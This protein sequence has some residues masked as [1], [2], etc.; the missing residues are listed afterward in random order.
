MAKAEMEKAEAGGLAV[1]PERQ[2]VYELLHQSMLGEVDL[3]ESYDSEE[4]QRALALGLLGSESL[5]ELYGAQSLQ[6]WSELLGKPM[7]VREVH[8]NPSKTDKGPGF[9]AVV[10]LADPDTGEVTTR[11]IGGWRPMAQLLATWG[12]G[13]LPIT[14]KVV[15]VGM[16]RQGQ[17]APLGLELV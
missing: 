11:H 1:L 15:E 5:E 3:M 9:Y 14:A 6:P 8:F 16:A 2:K 13:G 12:S 10:S 4:V 7:I 17:S